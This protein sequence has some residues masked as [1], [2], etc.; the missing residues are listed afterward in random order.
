MDTY[1]PGSVFKAITTAA[2]I[3]EGVVTL[4]SPENCKPYSLAGHTIDCWRK[5]GHGSEDFLHAVYNSCNPVFVKVGLTLGIDKFYRYV[6]LFGFQERTNIDIAGE[7]TT[8][9]YRNLWHK[10]P[11]EIDLAVSSFGQ[12]FQIS[13]IQL[14]TAYS[15]IANGGNLMQPYLVKQITDRD[16]NII[17]K[18]EPKVIR[19]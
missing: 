2:A 8:E 5:G 3:E 17:Q 6:R 4:S 7:P 19:K 15:A 10:D 16:G 13:P 9:E 18:N 1:E 11:K 14:V 12:R